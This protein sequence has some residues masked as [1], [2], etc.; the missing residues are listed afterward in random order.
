ME[1]QSEK[2][3][4]GLGEKGQAACR[5]ELTGEAE[6]YSITTMRIVDAIEISLK[7]LIPG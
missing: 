5:A 4:V 1:M 2:C 7:G 6:A 3:K